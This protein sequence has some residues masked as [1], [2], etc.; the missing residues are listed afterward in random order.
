M[1]MTEVSG[2]FFLKAY[3]RAQRPSVPKAR[4]Q[5]SFSLCKRVCTEE[6]QEMITRMFSTVFVFKVEI[7][8]FLKCF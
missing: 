1:G 8:Y 6:E 2:E 4:G 7:S 3:K 5:S